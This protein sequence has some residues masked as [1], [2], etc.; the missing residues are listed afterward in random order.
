[1]VGCPYALTRSDINNKKGIY[2]FDPFENSKK[3]I[4]NDYSPKFLKYKIK[5]ILNVKLKILNKYVANNYIDLVTDQKWALDFPFT[6]FLE[7]ING[8]KKINVISVLEEE[9]LDSLDSINDTDLSNFNIL[10]LSKMY[11]EN[12]NYSAKIKDLIIKK[13]EELYNKAQL[14]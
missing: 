6:A 14:N 4:E 11:V 9:Q 3:F 7:N 12:L 13:L 2:I 1:M 8:Y 5:D 10:K